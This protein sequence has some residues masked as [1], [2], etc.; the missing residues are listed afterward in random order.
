MFMAAKVA[1]ANARTSKVWPRVG[2]AVS[3]ANT[4]C[5]TTKAGT[6]AACAARSAVRRTSSAGGGAGNAL[7]VPIL[8]TP[9]TAANNSK[10]T[11]KSATKALRVR[12]ATLVRSFDVMVVS[13]SMAVSAKSQCH[14]TR[15]SRAAFTGSKLRSVPSERQPQHRTDRRAIDQVNRPTM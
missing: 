12:A 6:N 10:A 7:L 8:N 1:N 14:P 15:S 4:G 11:A 13:P 5:S 3:S 2:P 9:V